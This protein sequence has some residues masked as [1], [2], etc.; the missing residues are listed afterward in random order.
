MEHP[1]HHR[2]N[3]RGASEHSVKQAFLQLGYVLAEIAKK[4]TDK[5]GNEPCLP[6]EGA[7]SDG[8]QRED[9][10]SVVSGRNIKKQLQRRSK[11]WL[12]EE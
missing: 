1:D 4:A 10:S 9:P 2:P 11:Q 12:Q 3:I 7:L 5:E 8:C 6:S